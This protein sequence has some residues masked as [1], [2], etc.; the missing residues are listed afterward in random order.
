MVLSL[1]RSQTQ[2]S[3]QV[4]WR[5][6]CTGK[7]STVPIQISL[8]VSGKEQ[9]LVA[10]STQLGIRVCYTSAN[11]NYV[12]TWHHLNYAG[13]SETETD[14]VRSIL[15]Q[16]EYQFLIESWEGKGVPFKSHLHV[17]EVHPITDTLFCEHEDEGH[18]LKVHKCRCV[19]V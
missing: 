12:V 13:R 19:H 3:L 6:F 14:K 18:V 2:L 11:N 10:T 8:L 7:Q 4:S 5:R 9:Y 1:L 15:A 17:P 16:L